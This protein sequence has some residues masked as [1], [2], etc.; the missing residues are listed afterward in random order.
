MQS[1]R[2]QSAAT[3]KEFPDRRNDAIAALGGN[4]RQVRPA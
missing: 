2:W 1:D 3:G 4:I